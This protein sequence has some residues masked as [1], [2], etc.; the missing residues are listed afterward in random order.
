MTRIVDCKLGKTREKATR[1][2]QNQGN[3]VQENITTRRLAKHTRLDS[4]ALTL[5]NQPFLTNRG[6]IATRILSTA[7]ELGLETFAT[8]TDNDVSHTFNHDA[9][10]ALRLPSPAAY[11]DI[12]LLVNL[13][14]KN[15]IDAVHPGYGFLSENA[16]FS[17]AMREAGV[18]V[19]GPGEAILAATSD[20]LAARQLA[21]ESGVPV[22]PALKV[23]TGQVEDV[24][25]F[26]ETVGL[27]VMVKAVDG[28]GGR[29]I[30]LAREMGELEGLVRR[31]VEESPQKLVFAEKA[32]VD[33]WRHVEVQVVGDGEG[34]VRH[35]W[36]RE[37]S[38]QRRYQKVVEVAGSTVADRRIVGR[39]IEAAVRMAER[40]R[41]LMAYDQREMRMC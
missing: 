10:H 6:E 24:R 12:P 23:A 7:R 11:T 22:L 15:G 20:K 38:L 28:G 35:L 40:V 8:Y 16:G 5:T 4:H 31:A 29:G 39:V 17:A 9:A 25:S 2:R 33:R 34:N 19:T 37:C 30:R 14:K 36:E 3:Y 13:A 27:P 41:D 18:E 21:E 26:A 1:R 32:A